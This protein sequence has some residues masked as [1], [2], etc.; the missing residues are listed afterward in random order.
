MGMV[1]VNFKVVMIRDQSGLLYA[2]MNLLSGK[3]AAL[4]VILAGVGMTLMYEGGKSKNSGLNQVKIGLLKRAALLFAVGLSYYFIWPADILHYYGVYMLAVIMLLG[5]S[6]RIL[7]V[8]SVAIVLLY[9]LLL[10]V[11]DYEAGWNFTTLEYTDFFSING[12]FRNMF[13]NGF[14]PVIP[15]VA[16]MLTGVWVGR[17]NFGDHATRKRITII[18]LIFYIL[19]KGLSLI[20]SIWANNAGPDLSDDILTLAATEPMPPLPFYMLTATSLAV[21]IISLAVYLGQ[22]FSENIVVRGLVSAGQLALTN[23]FLHVVIGMAVIEVSFGKLERAFSGG[24][25]F[26]YATIFNVILVVFSH[27]WRK[28]YPRGPLEMLMRKITG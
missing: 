22:R 4:F 11:F 26:L 1:Y 15:W 17:M 18:A 3:A 14:H 7:Q 12:F 28:K 25:V 21:M 13:I 5:A 9:P 20:L 8:L 24:F 16:F 10:G 2:A 19:F 6:R 23:Y 27:L